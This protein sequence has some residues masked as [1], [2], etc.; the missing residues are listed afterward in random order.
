[1]HFFFISIIKLSKSA[2]TLVNVQKL[3]EA[4][5]KYVRILAKMV[6]LEM[7]AVQWVRW[8]NRKIAIRKIVQVYLKIYYEIVFY[9]LP[10]SA[11]K[12]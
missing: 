5:P 9:A 6:I 8:R 7:K 10:T 12:F 2:Q 4:G 11:K 1:M 3:A